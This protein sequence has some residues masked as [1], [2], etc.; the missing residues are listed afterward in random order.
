MHF[1]KNP[2][3]F[4]NECARTLQNAQYK[5][6][7][8]RLA[9]HKHVDRIS[10]LSFL[11]RWIN[12]DYRMLYKEYYVWLNVVY[13]GLSTSILFSSPMRFFILNECDRIFIIQITNVVSC[14]P[15]FKCNLAPY[16]A[17]QDFQLFFKAYAIHYNLESLWN[18][19]E[20][21]LV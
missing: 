18:S 7:L 15:G 3:Q 14:L 16:H 6:I 11:F 2:I 5:Y 19:I 8:E 17:L 20:D 4:W 1:C 21:L 10:R 9:E 12:F 13:V